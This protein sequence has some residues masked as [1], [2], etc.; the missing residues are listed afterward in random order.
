MLRQIIVYMQV[1]HLIWRNM[2]HTDP[3]IAVEIGVS[4][5]VLAVMLVMVHRHH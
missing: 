4:T 1:D 5:Y 3:A 2:L